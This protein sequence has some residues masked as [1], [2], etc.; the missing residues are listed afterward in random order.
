MKFPYGISNFNKLIKE[1]Y[2]YVDRTDQIP[3]LEEAGEQLLFL[4]P[5]RFGKSLLLNMLSN[6]YDL[7]MASEFD[8]LFGHLAIGKNPTE[9]HNQYLVMTWDF[10]RVLPM[11][12]TRELY[13]ALYGYLNVTMKAFALRYQSQLIA[14]ID[15]NDDA[16]ATFGSL[17]NM[18]NLSNHQLY[19][20]IDEYDNFANEVMASKVHKNDRYADLVYGEG[21]LKSLFKNIKAAASGEGLDRVFITGVSPVVMA[22]ISSGYNVATNI[23]RNPEF[24]DLCG[25]TETE[26]QYALYQVANECQQRGDVLDTNV[27]MKTMRQFYNGYCFNQHDFTSVYNPT[28]ALYFLKNL[29]QYCRYPD[30]LLDHNLGMDRDRINYIAQLP[31]GSALIQ[32][33]CDDSQ[34]VIVPQLHDRFGVEDLIKHEQEE[35]E[36]ASLLYYLGVLTQDKVVALGKLQLRVPNLVIRSLYVEKLRKLL[37]PDVQL[38]DF[39]QAKEQFFITGDLQPL[40]EFIQTRLNVFSNRDYRW[41]NE[42]AIKTAFMMLLFDDRLYIVDSEPELKRQYADFTLIARPDMRQYEMLDHVMEFKFVKLNDVNLNGKE[43]QSLSDNELQELPQ[44]QAAFTAAF[45]QLATYQPILFERYGEDIL[46]LQTTAV[47]AIGFERVVW[48]KK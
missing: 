35:E 46:R 40:C 11:G 44:V 30:N 26:I 39:R 10:S 41:V 23:Y 22:D 33:I 13:Q 17:V 47:V 25:F 20:F 9:K 8:T 18:V 36:L 27:A 1:G 14:P 34:Q 28:L 15:I 43:V 37:L 38:S 29:A 6:Y 42:F 3:L 21:L 5:R 45:T 48:R 32:R 16:A 4:R 31:N 19:L 12:S 7:A 24:N 2:F